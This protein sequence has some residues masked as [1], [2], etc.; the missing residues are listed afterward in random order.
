MERGLDKG[1]GG[2]F[3][4]MQFYRHFSQ[5]MPLYSQIR[6]NVC[7]CISVCEYVCVCVFFCV[8][9]CVSRS[10]DNMFYISHSYNLLGK[11]HKNQT[12]NKDNILISTSLLNHKIC[13]TCVL[14]LESAS[15]NSKN[16]VL[17]FIYVSLVCSTIVGGILKLNSILLVRK[18]S[19][20]NDSKVQ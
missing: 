1:E 4:I 3:Y 9:V 18:K 11:K 6:S 14:L 20:L 17:N 5:G 16:S 2:G 13:T 19:C 12:I 15:K 7:V 8:C 10:P